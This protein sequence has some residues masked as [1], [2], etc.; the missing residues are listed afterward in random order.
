MRRKGRHVKG[1]AVN[2]AKLTADQ[3]KEIASLV[4]HNQRL[5]AERYGVDRTMI[6]R[7]MRKKAWRH[8]W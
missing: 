5:L 7:I 8:L 2:T 4:G 1:E 3:V 6:G